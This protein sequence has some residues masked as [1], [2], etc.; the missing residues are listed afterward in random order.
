MALRTKDRVDMLAALLGER[1]V[2]RLRDAADRL[3]VSEMTVRRDVAAHA[4]R[5]AYLGGHI[6][7]AQAVEPEQPYEL[8]TAA[9]SHAA[10][11]RQ[12]CR[13]ATDLLTADDTIFVD[14]GTTLAHL[15]EMID[16]AMP[17]TVVCNALNLADRLAQRDRIRLILLGGVYHPATASFSGAPGLDMLDQ[18]GINIAFMS[19]AGLDSTRGATCGHFHEVAIKQKVMAQAQKRVLVID[20]SKLGRVKPAW[21]ARPD[22]FD[23]VISENGPLRLTAVRNDEI[24]TNI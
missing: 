24:I 21:F 9:D 12:A 20:D 8:S 2:V 17:L 15:V 22:A 7:P 23:L 3:G 18:L 5:F 19:A 4:A 13:H 11:K 1:G 16:P 10:A 14:C 6:M